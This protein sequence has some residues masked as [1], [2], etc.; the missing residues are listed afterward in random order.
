MFHEW[1]DSTNNF[2][3]LCDVRLSVNNSQKCHLKYFQLGRIFFVMLFFL[4]ILSTTYDHI[5]RKRC[6]KPN[7]LWTAFSI[8]NNWNNLV[9]INPYTSSDQIQCMNGI[10]VLSSMSIIIGHRYRRMQE[11]GNML[12]PKNSFE[13]TVLSFLKLYIYSVDSFQT[14][15]GTLVALLCIKA[16]KKWETLALPMMQP[17]QFFPFQRKIWFSKVCCSAIL[18]TCSNLGCGLSLLHELTYKIHN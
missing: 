18:E 5:K 1:S 2:W 14:I 4:I 6:E 3:F 12:E 13:M 15:S 9:R 11:A 10:K 8:V 17:F 7:R 16:F